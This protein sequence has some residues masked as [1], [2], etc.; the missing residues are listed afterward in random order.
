MQRFFNR[1]AWRN[2]SIPL[3]TGALF[4]LQ[5]VLIAVI[6]VL[7]FVGLGMVRNWLQTG[8]ASA[9]EMRTLSQDLQT[10]VETL[11]RLETRLVE[12]RYGW[13]PSFNL[14]RAR[15]EADYAAAVQEAQTSVERLEALAES[16]LTDDE[17]WEML[18]RELRAVRTGVIGSERSFTAMLN[19]IESF[20]AYTGM[21]VGRASVF[22]DELADVLEATG[23]QAMI[24][25]FAALRNLE[26]D[27][28]S[29]GDRM[30]LE[31]FR[32]ASAVFVEDYA[33]QMPTYNRLADIPS[34]MD[35]YRANVEQAAGQLAQLDAMFRNSQ[36]LKDELR[37]TTSRLNTFTDAQREVQL[38]R[39]A[40]LQNHL[41][42]VLIGSLVVMMAVGGYLTYL[43]GR[44]LTL[45]TRDLLRVLQRLG[46]GD[47]GARALVAGSDEFSQLASGFNEM[48][49]Q[50]EIA[51][52]GLEQRVAERT[53]DLTITAEIGRAVSARR[54]PR[55]L[56][57]EVVEL[58]RSRFGYYHAQVFLID[59]AGEMARLVASTGTAGRQL[60]A[61]QHALPV[62]SRSVIG[63]V[64]A[65]GEPVVTSDT[66][67]S[68]IHRRNELLPDTRSEMALPMRIGDKV[69]GALDVQSVAPN[70]FDA[71]IVAVFQIMADQLAI[72]LD[73]AFLQERL[74]E[75]EASMRAL[76]QRLTREAWDAYRQAR[77]GDAPLGYELR[78]DRIVP[79]HG[80]LP[81]PLDRAIASGSVVMSENGHDEGVQLAV[82]I[83]VRG[84]VIGAFGFGGD[85][86]RGLSE[87][88]IGLIEAVVERVGLALEHMRLV[89]ESS[90]RVEQEHILNEITARIVGST[91]V[92]EILQTTV[93][94]LG[95]V[96]RAPQTT[97]QLRR[98]VASD[99]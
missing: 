60:L 11:Q 57:N 40:S 99:E 66:D 50:L 72:A 77:V 32:N 4:L 86:L 98:E 7:A 16:V 27:V 13:G 95:R 49:R 42:L 1:L 39:V 58:I 79:R 54:D 5:M 56:M 26:A 92:D 75:L 33:A 61:R 2:L 71:D 73:N 52:A 24:N 48:A 22:G 59:E 38:A 3:K 55:V 21:T 51:F 45:S 69:I 18:E 82:P 31:A 23:N 68:G 76:E 15:F 30:A 8:V 46:Q 87:D 41:R 74:D 96:L 25:D 28:L 35:E 62:G 90:R 63:Q 36:D 65:R 67:S 93:R 43:F 10:K 97:V 80:D 20:S 91:D 44:S 81:S 85:T 83:K 94:E 19:L 89:E 9:V 29:T 12:Q 17:D 53:R 70:A 47:L 14:T 6:A 34:M 88:D 37:L 64:T 78:A 84:E